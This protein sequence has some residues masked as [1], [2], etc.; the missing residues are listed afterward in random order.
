MGFAG[1]FEE[2][3]AG[4]QVF[5]QDVVPVEGDDFGGVDRVAE[6]DFLIGNAGADDHRVGQ[7]RGG[8]DRF[9]VGAV[10]G[11]VAVSLERADEVF[12]GEFLD[13]NAGAL[14]VERENPVLAGA[15]GELAGVL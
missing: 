2:E 3:D 12:A 15:L 6:R 4:S 14:K 9:A 8:A 11:D 7:R 10:A 5:G 1:G 13:A